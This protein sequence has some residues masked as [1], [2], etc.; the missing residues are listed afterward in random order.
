MSRVLGLI[1]FLDVAYLWGSLHLTSTHPFRRVYSVGVTL[2]AS[3]SHENLVTAWSEDCRRIEPVFLAHKVVIFFCMSFIKIDRT[4]SWI[5][6]HKQPVC[7][8]IEAWFLLATPFA[9]FFR[10]DDLGIVWTCAFFPCTR[11][12]TK[13]YAWQMEF[14]TC[15]QIICCSRYISRNKNSLLL[16]EMS[17]LDIFSLGTPSSVYHSTVSLVYTHHKGSQIS[18]LQGASCEEYVVVAVFCEYLHLI[19]MPI[20]APP[21]HDPS[22]AA[23]TASTSQCFS[24]MVDRDTLVS[25][26]SQDCQQNSSKTGTTCFVESRFWCSFVLNSDWQR[27]CTTT[28]LTVHVN[29]CLQNLNF[30]PSLWHLMMSRTLNSSMSQ[31]PVY[32]DQ[33]FFSPFPTCLC[34]SHTP[35]TSGPRN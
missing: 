26:E 3:T 29:H 11:T 34:P 21:V 35:Q 19:L 5:W 17:P 20:H 16:L 25:L 24:G 10:P 6:G 27:Q 15:M 9:S 14:N 23:S 33:T 28:I 31:K 13:P 4:L 7:Q 8:Y 1:C 2:S 32:S 22:A 12:Y 18:Q 30:N